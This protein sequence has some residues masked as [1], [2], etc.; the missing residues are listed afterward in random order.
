MRRTIGIVVLSMLTGAPIQAADDPRMV[1]C[2]RY[3][4][5]ERALEDVEVQAALLPG[6]VAHALRG[7]DFGG[8]PRARA[9]K[10][11]A[12]A[13][14]VSIIDDVRDAYADMDI[15][16]KD[17]HR[18]LLLCGE[19]HG[20]HVEPYEGV[21]RLDYPETWTVDTYEGFLLD[22]QYGNKPR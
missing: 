17:R 13:A 18:R 3:A 7:I 2:H 19:L 8:G 5:L 21:P 14:L 4:A 6:A 11:E 1:D 10:A 16:Y 12:R 22:R 9:A 15:E 20:Y